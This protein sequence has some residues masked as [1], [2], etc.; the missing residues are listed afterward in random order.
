MY[1]NPGTK[2]PVLRFGIS[3]NSFEADHGAFIFLRVD[4]MKVV[5]MIEWLVYEEKDLWIKNFLL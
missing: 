3:A 4:W 1:S 5:F 2:R